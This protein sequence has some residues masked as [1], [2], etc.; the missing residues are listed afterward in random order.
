M[1]LLLAALISTLAI[2]SAFAQKDP[3]RTEL[4]RVKVQVCY[5]TDGD[6]AKA[7]EHAKP[8]PAAL[9]ERI[10]QDAHIDHKHYLILGEDTQALLRSYENWA[11]PLKPSDE[12]LVRFEAQGK[13]TK[14]N[15]VVD[16]EIWL[17]RKK[18]IKTDAL[19]EA[20]KPLLVLGPDWRGGHLIISLTLA[21][22]EKPAK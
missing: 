8:A 19:L 11:Q 14:E 16:L 17:S 9:V 20:D 7:G 2:G 18:I 12:V 1:K 13:P 10:K 22:K 5:A 4:A 21:P 3:G 6:P 15:A